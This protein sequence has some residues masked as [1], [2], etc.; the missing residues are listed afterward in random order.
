MP[1]LELVRLRLRDL[2]QHI[3]KARRAVVYSN[4]ADEIGD[5]V[6]HQLPQVGEAD[7]VRFKQKARHFLKAHED[8]IVLHKLRQGRPLTATDLNELEKMLLDA[9]VGEAG[10]IERARET[11]QGFGRFVRS[12]VGLDR[13]AVS[14]AFGEFLSAGTASAAQIEFINLIVEHLTDQGIMDPGLLYEPPFTDIAP[15]GPDQV[16]D[17]ERVTRLFAKIRAINDSAVA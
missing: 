3:D 12:L 10:D 14:E 1:L 4:F 11:S 5:G 7:F 13:A 8:H 16:F 6:E 2:V 9:G 17:E 15:T